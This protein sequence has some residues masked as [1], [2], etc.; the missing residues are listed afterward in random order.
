VYEGSATFNLMYF[1]LYASFCLF[2]ELFQ[3]Q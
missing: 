3:I 2:Y 1:E